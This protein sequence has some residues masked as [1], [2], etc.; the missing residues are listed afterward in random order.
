MGIP[1]FDYIH[2]ITVLFF[3]ST[4]SC[5][6]SLLSN[7]VSSCFN[8]IIFSFYSFCEPLIL[9]GIDYMSTGEVLF[10]KYR[11]LINQWVHH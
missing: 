4:D 3:I 8:I 11:Y 10:Q 1:Y 9:T 7:I 5:F 6:P 2:P